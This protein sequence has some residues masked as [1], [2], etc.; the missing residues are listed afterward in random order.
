[1]N[2]VSVN[3]HVVAPASGKS[4]LINALFGVSGMSLSIVVGGES[5][6]KCYS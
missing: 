2:K 4:K 1:M 6:G 5:E 3:C